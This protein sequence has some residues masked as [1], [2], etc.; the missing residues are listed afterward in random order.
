MCVLR[1]HMRR[2]LGI[3]ISRVCLTGLWMQ[4]YIRLNTNM[5]LAKID[6]KSSTCTGE[7]ADKQKTFIVQHII[8]TTV[9]RR[10]RAPFIS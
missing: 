6:S 5:F 8:S 7:K 1:I 10:S 9:N 3:T 2:T 4:N